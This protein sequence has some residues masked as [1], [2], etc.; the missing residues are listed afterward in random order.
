VLRELG[1]DA[2]SAAQLEPVARAAPALHAA[3]VNVPLLLVAGGRDEKVELEAVIDYAARLQGLGKPVSLLVDPDEGHNTRKPVVRRAVQHLLLQ[4][5]HR[6]LGGPPV[7][8]PDQEVARYLERTMRADG[9]LPPR[10]L[11]G[12]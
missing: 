4:M 3:R 7:A 10:A 2:A 9:A 8:A 5:L 11:T 1:I 12:G 6:H